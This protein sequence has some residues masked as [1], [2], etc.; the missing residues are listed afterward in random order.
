MK[1]LVSKT[2][3]YGMKEFEVGQ[4]VKRV[5]G[6]KCGITDV[7]DVGIVKY[8]APYGH[9]HIEL[10]N[11]DITEE[12]FIGNYELLEECNRKNIMSTLVEKFR[13][14]TASEP[15]KTFVEKGVMDS[16]FVLTKDGEELFK[17]F[18]FEKLKNEFKT[19]VVDKIVI[20]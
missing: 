6:G 20:E 10:E 12:V 4:R 1:S 16:K 14:L 17:T 2:N 7:G 15:E 11:G 3:R 5:R 19:E 18:L 8:K 9:A 13:L